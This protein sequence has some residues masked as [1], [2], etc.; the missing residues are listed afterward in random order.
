MSGMVGGAS[1]TSIYVRARWILGLV[2]SRYIIVAHDGDQLRRKAATGLDVTK[3]DF[4]SLPPRFNNQ[5][6]SILAVAE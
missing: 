6:G 4:A 5:N 3:N 2:Q 1:S